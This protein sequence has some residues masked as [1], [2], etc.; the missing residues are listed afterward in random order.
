[1]T[2][3]LLLG[4]S[5]DIGERYRGIWGLFGSYDYI[6]PQTFRVS[7]TALSLGTTGQ[8]RL[9]EALALQ[10]TLLGGVGYTAVGTVNGTN[11]QD[12]HYGVAPQALLGLRVIFGDRASLDVTGREFFV[13]GVSGA[14]GG[15]H[16]NIG[17]A[18]FSFTLRLLREH[19]IAFKYLWSRRDPSYPGVNDFSQSHG[20][21]GVYYAYL[22]NQRFGAVDWR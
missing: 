9:S 17:R 7:S 19:A 5:Y 1:M 16:D 10:G 20:T 15:G 8:L 6:A 11:D 12:Y 21:F 13:S 2:R 3:G 18:D 14:G 22:G 4:T